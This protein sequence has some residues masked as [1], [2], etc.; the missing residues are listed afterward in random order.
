MPDDKT[1][2]AREAIVRE[3]MASEERGDF[4]ATVKTFHRPRYEVAPTLETHDGEEAVRAFLEETGVAFPGFRFSETVVHHADDAIIVETTFEG[5]HDGMWRGLPPTGRDVS[6]RMSNTFVFE[7]DKLVCERLY[8]DILTILRQIGI[9]R[10]P[11]SLGG[12][13]TT[14]ANHP[15]AVSRAFARHALRKRRG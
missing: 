7:G 4:A 2:A 15:V 14:F 10:D 6:Y 13:I 12:R 5:R 1:R 3:H 11:T 8:F 9:A